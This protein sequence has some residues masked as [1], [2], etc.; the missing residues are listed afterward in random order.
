[1]TAAIPSAA[2]GEEAW[3]GVDGYNRA[4]GYQNRLATLSSMLFA[5]RDLTALQHGNHVALMAVPTDAVDGNTEPVLPQVETGWIRLGQEG[6]KRLRHLYVSHTTESASPDPAVG[7]LR[8]SY[9]DRPYPYAAYTTVGELPGENAYAR[10]RLRLGKRGYGIT[11][12]V[13]Q[14]TPTWLSRLHDIAVDQT[15]QDRGKL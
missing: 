8:V 6:V 15:A 3:W 5:D 10:N 7:R 1:M 11:V 2:D 12:K 14:L 4:A 9:R 13:E